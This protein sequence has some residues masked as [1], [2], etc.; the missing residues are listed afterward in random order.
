MKIVVFF[1][2]FFGKMYVFSQMWAKTKKIKDLK[3]FQTLRV[4]IVFSKF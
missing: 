4:E 1:V 3:F 2:N